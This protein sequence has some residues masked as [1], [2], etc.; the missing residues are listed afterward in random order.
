MKTIVTLSLLFI[1]FLSYS[2]TDSLFQYRIGIKDI[3]TIGSAKLVQEPLTDL[4]RT[5]PTFQSDLGTFIFESKQDID[6]QQLLA[7]LPQSYNNIT[8]F[9]KSQIKVESSQ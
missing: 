5:T 4:F 8:Y 6:R 9:K 1:S 3:T 2:Q 7:I